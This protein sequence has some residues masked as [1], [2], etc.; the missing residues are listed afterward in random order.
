MNWP[1]EESTAPP[2][3]EDRMG[4]QL[5]PVANPRVIKTPWAQAECITLDASPLSLP[6]VLPLSS[7]SIL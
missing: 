7:P 2:A 4:V 6:H 1:R 5:H 3:L